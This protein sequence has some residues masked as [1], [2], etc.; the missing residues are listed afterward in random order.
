L[1]TGSIDVGTYHPSEVEYCRNCVLVGIVVVPVPPRL[2]ETG[3][4]ILKTFD[5]RV[6]PDP[7]L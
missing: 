5:D 1:P 2:T 3:A 7:A 4:V 6:S